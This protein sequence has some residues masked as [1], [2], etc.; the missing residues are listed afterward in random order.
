MERKHFTEEI[1]ATFSFAWFTNTEDNFQNNFPMWNSFPKSQ[2]YFPFARKRNPFSTYSFLMLFSHLFSFPNHFPFPSYF[3][4]KDTKQT[5]ISTNSKIWY[6]LHDPWQIKQEI[7]CKFTFVFLYIEYCGP[8]KRLT[9][10]TW[11]AVQVSDT[12]VDPSVRYDI[13][14][15]QG[16]SD[17]VYHLLCVRGYRKK[18]PKGK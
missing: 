15:I 1:I 3:S 5:T 10:I 7:V 2:N 8:T 12:S 14:R 9:Y 11:T 18:K 4:N 13:F 16:Y 6:Q 17:T